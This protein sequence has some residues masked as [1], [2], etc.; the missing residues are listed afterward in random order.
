[1][2]TLCI[3]RAKKNVERATIETFTLPFESMVTEVD[4][5]LSTVFRFSVHGIFW[6]FRSHLI[7][8]IDCNL[9]SFACAICQEVSKWEKY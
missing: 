1:M 2:H 4:N 8:Q 9:V 6:I 7:A 3:S 5:F